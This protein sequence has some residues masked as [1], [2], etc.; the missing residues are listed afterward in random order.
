MKR[1]DFSGTVTDLLTGPIDY[2]A[3]GENEDE[4]AFQK[5]S[6]EYYERRQ[7]FWADFHRGDW[8]IAIGLYLIISSVA[9]VVL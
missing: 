3:G 9:F 6:A 5:A 8:W 7:K 1:I 2:E 4:V